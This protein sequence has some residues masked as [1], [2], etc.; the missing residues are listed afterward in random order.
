V[1]GTYLFSRLFHPNCGPTRRLVNV[2]SA[3]AYGPAELAAMPHRKAAVLSLT[4]LHGA[5]PCATGYSRHAV[6]RAI[7]QRRPCSSRCGGT[8]SGPNPCASL[9]G[10]ITGLVLSAD[11]VAV[12]SLM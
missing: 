7:L 8:G 10:R 12:A 6:I 4:K 2:C 3:A 9:R 1:T 11:E 5:R